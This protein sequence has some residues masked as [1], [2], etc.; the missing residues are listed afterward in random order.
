[1]LVTIEMPY[2]VV[3][4]IEGYGNRVKEWSKKAVYSHGNRV[5]MPVS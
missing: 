1:L 4:S 3:E 2:R 5:I